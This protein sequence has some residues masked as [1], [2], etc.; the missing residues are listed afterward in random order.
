MSLSDRELLDRYI[1]RSDETAFRLLVERHLALVHGVALRVTGNED[2]AREVSQRTLIRLARRAALVPRDASLPAWLH[3]MS[4]HLAIDLVRG[5]D[6][7]KKRELYSTPPCDSMDDPAPLPSW[8]ALA[9][10]IDDLVNRLPAA[11][12]DV[13]LRRYYGNEPYAQIGRQLGLSEEAAR[14]RAA[15]ALDK[16]RTLLARQGI[17]TTSIALATLLP[18]HAAP[19]AAAALATSIV[20]AAQGVVPLVP[21][22]FHA[23]LVAMN[24]TQKLSIAG[25]A[26]FFLASV[27]YSL[28]PAGDPSIAAG[29]SAASVS[30][31]PAAG[32]G[33]TPRR[34]RKG[35]PLPGTPE[36]RYQR[37]VEILSIPDAIAKKRELL[38]FV[39]LLPPALFPEIL[40]ALERID[41]KIRSGDP[42]L[43][44]VYGAWVH[45]DPLAAMAAAV[46]QS[47]DPFLSRQTL[48]AW[49][50]LD[51]ESAVAWAADHPDLLGDALSGMGTLDLPGALKILESLPE[52]RRNGTLQGMYMAMMDQPQAL[53]RLVEQLSPGPLRSGLLGRFAPFIATTDPQSIAALLK[54]DPA[55]RK[56]CQ[57]PEIY[58]RWARLDAAGAGVALADL[59]PGPDR[60]DAV[61]AVAR[62][63]AGRQIGEAFELLQRYPEAATEATKADLIRNAAWNQMEESFAYIPRISDE[64]LRNDT[65]VRQLQSWRRRLDRD[66]AEAWIAAHHDELPEPVREAMKNPPGDAPDPFAE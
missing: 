20:T 27:A 21:H 63:T 2:L 65:W 47:N 4:R 49:A 13:L 11:D 58:D 12:R 62:I 10:F 25:A 57:V 35:N 28:R 8:S 22:A 30:S 31:G 1:A 18:A 34:P 44:M 53:V 5:E 16:L 55:A 40:G 52:E 64:N 50:S 56:G 17:A 7:R 6:R 41:P 54:D 14:K 33:L 45:A 60:R 9:P 48:A 38:A 42:R 29:G 61:V 24:T 37:L 43:A 66:K 51:P 32:P 3:R 59:A 46:R 39:D 23:A 36:G 26:V 19:P 15:R